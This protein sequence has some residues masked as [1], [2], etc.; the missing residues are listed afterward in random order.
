MDNYDQINQHMKDVKG[1]L[2]NIENDQ[3]QLA[4][5]VEKYT[6]GNF[7]SFMRHLDY[8]YDN[9][10]SPNNN[11]SPAKELADYLMHIERLSKSANVL[12]K[13]IENSDYI[14]VHRVS[15]KNDE[16]RNHAW[17]MWRDKTARWVLGAFSAV[18]VYSTFVWLSEF[19]FIT[20]PVRDL[21][22][23]KL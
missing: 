20:V 11:T 2:V 5:A 3:V 1:Y 19:S 18:I 23:P 6:D 22:I 15:L 9:N 12:F 17:K 8:L 10:P 4:H 7:S 13:E 14:A 21:I 16:I